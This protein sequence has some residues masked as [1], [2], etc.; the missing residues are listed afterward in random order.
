ML[1]TSVSRRARHLRLV[2]ARRSWPVLRRPERAAGVARRDLNTA[3]A[4]G[5]PSIGIRMTLKGTVR[6][7]LAKARSNNLSRA[8]PS[9][10]LRIRG[11]EA[12]GR[13]TIGDHDDAVRLRIERVQREEGVLNAGAVGRHGLAQFFERLGQRIGIVGLEPLAFRSLPP[14]NR[15]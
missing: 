3:G 15:S 9:M 8:S 12:L 5:S 13:Q 1:K 14:A 7:Y 11:E 10:A 2:P 4:I 6:G